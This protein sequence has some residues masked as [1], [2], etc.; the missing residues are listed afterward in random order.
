MQLALY[1]GRTRLF[2]R[3]VQWW[4][5][6]PYSHCE[7][8]FSTDNR[9]VSVCGSSSYL[10]GGVRIKHMALDPAKWDLLELPGLSDA[11]VRHWFV[12]HDGQ[13]YDLIG[14]FGFVL[15][16]VRESQT[17]WFCSEAC[18]AAIGLGDAWRYSPGALAALAASLTT[19]SLAG[20]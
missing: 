9:G 10:D 12:V 16:F 15:P 14:L 11:Q 13:R 18:A 19:S 8:V 3:A 17:R 20:S 4:T 1:K 6:S 7:L 2:D 5:R